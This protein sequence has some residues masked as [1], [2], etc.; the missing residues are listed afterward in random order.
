MPDHDRREDDPRFEGDPRDD[1]SSE[2]RP[3]PASV[4]FMEMMRQAAARAQA[5]QRP[6]DPVQP[7][8]LRGET[9]AAASTQTQTVMTSAPPR[10]PD[11]DPPAAPPQ[12]PIPPGGGGGNGGGKRPRR[13]VK[14]ERRALGAFGGFVRSILIVVVAAGLMAT[15]FTW[16]TPNAFIADDVRTGLSIAIATSAATPIPTHLPTPNWARR[17]GVVAGHR[18]P[19]NDPGAVCS[20]GLTEAEINFDVAQ[21]VVQML[22]GLGYTVDLLDEFDPRLDGYQAAALV[23]IHSNTCQPFGG[24]VVSGYLI[25]APEARVSAR[26]SDDI[27]V[28]CIA[29]TYAE[30][31]GLE[32]HP[33]VTIDMSDY[34]TFR[35]I[36]ALTPA[37]II[38]LGFMLA[39]RE[40]LTE[41]RED[42]AKAITDGVR[43]YLEPRV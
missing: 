10:A 23:S 7:S 5:A 40:L 30:A 36:H 8:P 16:W 3:I 18:G 31:T 41:R 22:R 4:T 34:H 24:E 32:R 14:R 21:R 42:L 1:D 35:E 9:D 39:D 20:D 28:E 25:A 6:R 26:G 19:E 13:R 29:G 43:C 38:E 2:N 11:D 15:I 37:A 12:P 33:G 17:I 27:L